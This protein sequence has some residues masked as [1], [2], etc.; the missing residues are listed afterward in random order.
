[1][2]VGCCSLLLV[3]QFTPVQ[4]PLF[5]A[6]TYHWLC[7]STKDVFRDGKWNAFSQGL[8]WLRGKH[9]CICTRVCWSLTSFVLITFVT[10]AFSALTLLVGRQEGHPARKNLSDEVLSSLSVWSK[11]QMIC[12]WSG[13]CHCHPIISAWENPEWFILLVPAYPCLLYTSDAADE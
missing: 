7:S 13:W 11:V 6:G 3:A 10:L 4:A 9:Q 2:N 5:A 12:I 8:W 1:M